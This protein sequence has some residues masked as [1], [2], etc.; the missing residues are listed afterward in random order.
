MRRPAGAACGPG[1]ISPIPFPVK[2]AP[3]VSHGGQG[4]LRRVK[5]VG[6]IRTSDPT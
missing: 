4:Y 1:L 5:L 6:G 2:M 3:M